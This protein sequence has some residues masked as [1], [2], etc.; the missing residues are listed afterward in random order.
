MEK[1]E[2]IARL[3]RLKE[4]FDLEQDKFDV[5]TKIKNIDKWSILKDLADTDGMK[6]FL[7]WHR[8]KVNAI[9]KLLALDEGMSEEERK[10]LILKREIYKEVLSYFGQADAVIKEAEAF[11]E[12]ELEVKE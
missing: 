1:S 12:R 4:Q 5:E 6:M 2:L 11:V 7:E 8:D 10:D 3:N 9:T